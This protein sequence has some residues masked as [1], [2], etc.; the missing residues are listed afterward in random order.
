MVGAQCRFAACLPEWTGSL[1]CA[2]TLRPRPMLQ[3]LIIGDHP[4]LEEAFA[5]AE[6][7]DPTELRALVAQQ[8]ARGASLD[9]A[10][11]DLDLDALGIGALGNAGGGG[12]RGRTAS[13]AS[14]AS[15]TRGGGPGVAGDFGGLDPMF[16]FDD[17]PFDLP[18]GDGQGGS[19]RQGA[20]PGDPGFARPHGGSIAASADGKGRRD[21]RHSFDFGASM[22]GY[23]AL[24]DAA[25]A[26][27]NGSTGPAGTDA[28]ATG[29]STAAAAAAAAASGQPR[30]RA[31]FDIRMGSF[32]MGQGGGSL[33]MAGMLGLDSGAVQA[34]AFGMTPP[35]GALPFN[36]RALEEDG[37]LM[38]LSR[39]RA[40]SEMSRGSVEQPTHTFRPPATRATAPPPKRMPAPPMP[41]REPAPRPR[42][43]G[44]ESAVGPSAVGATSEALR[45]AAAAP[46]APE[47]LGRGMRTRHSTQ[48]AMESRT[49]QRRSG[50]PPAGQ[51]GSA[52]VTIPTG[53][54][55]EGKHYIG[56]Y[57]PEARE[58][59]LQRFYEGRPRRVWHRRVKYDVRKN[60][61][62]SRVRVKGRF[63]KKSD[64]DKLR[65]AH[66]T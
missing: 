20:A 49:R 38:S 66:G 59:R 15:A 29:S 50:G 13:T 51:P 5:K 25:A 28:A 9:A 65:T 64:E 52:P 41:K 44:T 16:N 47:Q 53:E 61:A 11:E 21:P 19:G 4:A 1:S 12:G 23:G 24:V 46:P 18:F 10:V 34:N 30:M 31:S 27:A 14:A 22:G 6:K 39:R 40:D 48:A 43:L 32:D 35:D 54:K 55:E 60:F 57:S 8:R 37:V 26:A 45:A 7:G 3:D 63:V 2:L 33:D 36:T 42:M 58:A 17:I 62:D 56:A